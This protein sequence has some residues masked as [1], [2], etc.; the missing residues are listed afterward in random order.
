MNGRQQ[1]GVATQALATVPTLGV[2]PDQ[3]GLSER[4]AVADL[5]GG[6][7]GGGRFG[8]GPVGGALVPLGADLQTVGAGLAAFLLAEL[9]AGVLDVDDDAGGRGGAQQVLDVPAARGRQQ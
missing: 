5:A 3:D 2:V 6:G 1:L 9:L 4:D 7:L 8:G